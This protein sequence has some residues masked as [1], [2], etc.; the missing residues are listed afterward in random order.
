METKAPAVLAV[1]IDNLYSDT[2]APT[3]VI[4]AASLNES[5]QAHLSVPTNHKSNWQTL[6]N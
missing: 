4:E 6:L 5:D 1:A 3:V 2:Q